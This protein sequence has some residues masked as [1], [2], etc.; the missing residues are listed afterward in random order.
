[1]GC[2]ACNRRRPPPARPPASDLDLCR[3][4]VRPPRAWLGAAGPRIQCLARP[5]LFRSRHDLFAGKRLEHALA[6]AQRFSAAALSGV[7]KTNQFKDPGPGLQIVGRTQADLNFYSQSRFDNL[8]RTAPAP[9]EMG[10][11]ISDLER[12]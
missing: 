1:M 8:S 3:A 7:A 11:S 6:L 4:A 12:I 9:L 5:R 2:V 10:L